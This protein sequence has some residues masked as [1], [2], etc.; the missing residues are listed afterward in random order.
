MYQSLGQRMGAQLF[1][2]V[3]DAKSLRPRITVAKLV[4]AGVATV[5]H[6]LTL[7]FM[8]A[9]A[10]LILGGSS[11]GYV[12]GGIFCLLVAATLRPRLGR[13]PKA[14]VPRAKIPEL[15]AIVDEL[16]AAL[17]A[18]HVDGI[19]ISSQFNRTAAMSEAAIRRTAFGFFSSSLLL[20]G[21]PR[22]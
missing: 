8:V 19:L 5:V 3:R 10:F 22:S 1:E 13:R 6:G 15:S 16:G 17:G 20:L 11:F 2:E 12:I 9:G 14:V 18:G 21:R 4:A 7:A